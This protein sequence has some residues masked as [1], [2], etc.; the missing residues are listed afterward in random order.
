MLAALLYLLWARAKKTSLGRAITAPPAILAGVCF[1]Y[2]GSRFLVLPAEWDRSF[3][4]PYV[5]SAFAFLY[6]M[7]ERLNASRSR[8]SRELS[9]G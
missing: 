6:L 1:A 4:A 2:V 8:S 7:S 9:L 5:I 3:S